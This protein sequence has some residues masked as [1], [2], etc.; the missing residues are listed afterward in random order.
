MR[1][2]SDAEHTM[3]SRLD[4][5]TGALLLI[6]IGLIFWL[7]IDVWPWILFVVAVPAF[8]RGIGEGDV[9]AGL[10]PAV[11]LVGLGVIAWLDIWWPGILILVGFSI[12]VEK[13]V[14]PSFIGEKAKRKPKRGLPLPEDEE[15]EEWDEVS[16]VESSHEQPGTAG[17]R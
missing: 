5:A 14:E 16:A 13:M 3:K 6:G 12:L 15:W 8:L 10:K 1:C 17:R 11:W 9:G 7:N 4:Q 2:E